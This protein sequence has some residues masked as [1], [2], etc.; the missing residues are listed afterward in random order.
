MRVFRKATGQTPIEYLVRLRIQK[1]TELL[2]NTDFSITEIAL[3]VGFNDSN[4]FTRQ[5]RNSL[6]ESPRSYRQKK[7]R[8]H[9]RQDR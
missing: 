5:F 8:R 6:G 2:R 9:G 7:S 3:Q 1:S 4:Y